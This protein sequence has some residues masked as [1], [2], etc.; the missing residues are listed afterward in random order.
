MSNKEFNR[1]IAF[2]FY[3][4]WKEDAD[5]IEEDFG[6]DGKV[7]FYDAIINY[8][9]FEIEPE[10][11]APVKYFWSTIKE[12]I[13][14]SQEHRSRGFI[15]EDTEITQKIIDYKNN[16]PESTQRDIADAVG[17]S[18]GKV[19]KVLKSNYSTSINTDTTTSTITSTTMNM[20]TNTADEVK[21]F[22]IESFK[23]KHKWKQIQEDIQKQFNQN[24]KYDQIKEIIDGYKDNNNVLD[25]IKYKIKQE[26][27]KMALEEKRKQEYQAASSEA[28]MIIDA[29]KNTFGFE[30]TLKEIMET[31]EKNNKP[32][33]TGTTN[34]YA[35]NINTMK[36]FIE[37]RT[38]N[39]HS[40]NDV[41]KKWISYCNSMYNLNFYV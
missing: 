6:S 16:N 36:D 11:K 22:V 21:V 2:T 40:W 39:C 35:F 20:N 19:N 29:C 9:L 27:E 13:D 32:Y 7:R 30:P 26:K 10:M 14:A 31:Y 34:Y 24:I 17:C 28:Y 33:E 3:K 15:K 37:N 38:S 8:A 12:K 41:C 23:N 4:E 25:N 5:S 18:L 1:S